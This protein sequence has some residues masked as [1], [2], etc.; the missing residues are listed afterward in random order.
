MATPVVLGI[1]TIKIWRTALPLNAHRETGHL[2]QL[3]LAMVLFVS[4][5]KNE[6]IRNAIIR[7]RETLMEYGIGIIFTLVGLAALIGAVC[8]IRSSMF[9]QRTWRKTTGVVIGHQVS[10]SDNQ[11]SFRAEVQFVDDSGE[12]HIF[13]AATGSSTRIHKVGDSLAVLFNPDDPKYAAVNSFL[14][15]YMGAVVV[16]FMS[17]VF[18][19]IGYFCLFH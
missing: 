17:A 3:A 5:F 11:P 8:L 14:D 12:Q 2:F 4:I 15:L 18:L 1:I 16:A 19:G 7:E 10:H 13:A 9:R 6:K